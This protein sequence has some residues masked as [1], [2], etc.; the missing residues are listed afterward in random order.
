[1]AGSRIRRR[2]RWAS[3]DD[4]SGSSCTTLV[5]FDSVLRLQGAVDDVTA[6]EPTHIKLS[7][8]A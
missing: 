4:L 5:F 3:L 6:A 1:M 2:H 8:L 7:V